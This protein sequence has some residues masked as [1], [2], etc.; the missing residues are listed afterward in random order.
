MK[1]WRQYTFSLCRRKDWSIACTFYKLTSTCYLDI[2]IQSRSS[3]STCNAALYGIDNLA[4]NVHAETQP[5]NYIVVSYLYS[6]ITLSVPPDAASVAE[7]SG[8]VQV[9]ATLSD[10]PAGGIAAIDIMLATSDGMN[11]DCCLLY[12]RIRFCH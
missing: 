10:V 7:E 12:C 11:N 5:Y 4:R 8:S 9:C 6:A 3:Q 2:W 1:I